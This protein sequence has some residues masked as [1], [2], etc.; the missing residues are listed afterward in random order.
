MSA[1]RSGQAARERAA[2]ERAARERVSGARAL[3]AVGRLRRGEGRRL[4]LSVAL[5]SG[6]MAASIGLL[7]SSGYL[8][9][10]AAQH[11]EILQLM[12]VIVAVRGLGMSR[13]LLRYGERLSS[14]DLALRQLARLRVRFY[15]RLTPLLPG[16]VRRG[17][18][19]LLARFVGDV[20]A[21]SDLYLRAI[22]PACV[23]LVV[24]AGASFAGW[25]L[26][27]AAGIV[28]CA[29]LL[30]SAT[31]LPWLGSALAARTDR[32]QA[33]VRARLTEQMVETI[34]GAE[35]LL[36]YGRAQERIAAL[37]DTDRELRRLGRGDAAASALA[38]AFGV[39]LSGA[40]L[41]AVLIVGISAVHRGS[42]PGV[43]L[44]AL[45]FLLLGAHEAITPLPAAVRSLRAGAASARRL[46]E[47]GSLPAPVQDPARPRAVAGGGA[48]D[49]EGLCFRYE[50]DLPAVLEDL[51]LRLAPGEH[52]ALVGPSGIGKSTLAEL[53]VRFREPQRGRIALDGVDL[54]ELTQEDLRRE[55]LLCGQDAHLF[56]TSVRENLLL[57]APGAGEEELW[58]ALAAVELDGWARALPQGLDTLV[59]ADGQ[60][61][62]G[63]QRQRIALARALLADARFLILD[64]PSVH[65]DAALAR[66]V[67]RNLLGA[68]RGRG[69]LVITHDP[70]LAA[71]CDRIVRMREP[72]AGLDPAAPLVL[73]GDGAVAQS[74]PSQRS[75]ALV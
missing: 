11:P 38:G 54:R 27:P 17:G 60:L 23:A 55:V 74:R 52:V 66:R 69:V 1:P 3:L 49:V 34:D 73:A 22:V 53:L 18:G 43:L 70:E 45:A 48:L 28:V 8:I 37:A 33:T 13:A 75:V 65:L 12:V 29:C 71:G 7:A 15:E 64:E 68:A 6:A 61:V 50:P 32:R 56:N 10:R 24:I 58:R 5:S 21:L 19:E 62:S 39:A 31:V 63:G 26:L 46:Q 4:A 36:L 59:G 30:A 25:L 16:A 9:S 14:H 42:L 47:V 40:G 72:A 51:D 41:I 20:D 35:E 57:A 67:M 2:R 44:A